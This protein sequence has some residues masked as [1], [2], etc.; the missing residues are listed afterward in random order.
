MAI[1][2]KLNKSEIE[3]ILSRFPALPRKPFSAKGI[4][5]GT[6]NTYYRITYKTGAVYYLKI[7]EVADEKR[8]SDE[9]RIFDHL[10]RFQ[11]KLSH[12]TPIPEFADSGLRYTPFQ[13][14][15]ALVI[16]ELKGVS[17]FKNDLTSR[18]LFIIGQNIA[19]WHRL[20][21]DPKISEHRF[22]LAGQKKVFREISAALKKKHP[23]LFKMIQNKLAEFSRVN[24]PN[25]K[26]VLI[27]AD[28]FPENILW[29]GNRLVGILD[30][31]AAGRGDALFDVAVCLHALCHDGK[32]FIRAKINSFLK[33]YFDKKTLSA[34]TK[35]HLQHALELTAMRFLL[36]RLRDVELSPTGRKAKPF[37]DY[38]EY[39]KRFGEIEGLRQ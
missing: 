16:P 29:Q 38:R 28:L 18:R 4:A 31:D 3:K 8:L 30:F 27:H 32:N 21:I 14:K 17:H 37:K 23:S 22:A 15:F 36:T 10:I 7:D 5:L 19:E 39:V 35:K 2:T 12:T 34:E 26:R 25:R 6:V 1:Y 9:I 11:K 13:N 24:L 20:P 33:G